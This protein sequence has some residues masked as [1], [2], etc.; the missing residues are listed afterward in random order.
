MANSTVDSVP[1]NAS[2]NSAPCSQVS[3]DVVGRNVTDTDIA[4]VPHLQRGVLNMYRG[5]PPK[6]VP[7][8]ATG[9]SSALT[10]CCLSL[11]FSMPEESERLLDGM[12]QVK[13]TLLP[14]MPLPSLPSGP[15]YILKLR[16]FCK[17]WYS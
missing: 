1:I 3:S 9:I 10:K 5:P 17:E 16:A 12:H 13:L 14:S 6:D 8:S 7:S 4:S 15:C 2:L 11:L